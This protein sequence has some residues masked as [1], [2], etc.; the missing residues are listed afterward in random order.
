MLKHDHEYIDYDALGQKA[1]ED[2]ERASVAETASL[3]VVE[4]DKL[5]EAQRQ[6]PN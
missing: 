6:P 3:E 1:A 2:A 4:G 5:L